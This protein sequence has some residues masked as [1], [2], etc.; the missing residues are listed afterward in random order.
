MAEARYNNSN[1]L[2]FKMQIVP[3]FKADDRKQCVQL[4][5]SG[6]AETA[7]KYTAGCSDSGADS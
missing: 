4:F 6:Q 7:C 2:Q 3:Q 5:G 1:N